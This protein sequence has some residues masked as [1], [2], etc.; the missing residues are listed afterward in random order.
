[1]VLLI[2]LQASFVIAGKRRW[3]NGLQAAL[4]AK[5]NLD[6]NHEGIILNS[7]SLQHYLNH[8]PKLAGMTGTAVESADEFSEFYSLKTFVVPTNKPCIRI[9]KPDKIFTHKDAKE[10]AL[11]SK[12]IELHKNKQP[13]LVG[14]RTNH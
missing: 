14:T 2:S 8:Y 12:I 1:M 11:I 4:E 3:P 5:E 10:K 13:L 6:I 7:I 9:N